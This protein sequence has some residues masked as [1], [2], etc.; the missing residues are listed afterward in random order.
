MTQPTL[1]GRIREQ[2]ALR[3]CLDAALESQGRLILVCGEAGIGK[4]TLVADLVREAQQRGARVATGHCYDLTETPPY[5]P[6]TEILERL[7]AGAAAA[8]GHTP[9]AAVPSTHAPGPLLSTPVTGAP[10][11]AAFG[12]AAG[13][14]GG[15]ANQAGLFASVR[16]RLAAAAAQQPLLV[17][18][19]DMHWSD[20]GSLELLRWIARNALDMRL[21]LVGTY[22]PADIT[23]RHPLFALLPLLVREVDPVRLDL[24]RLEPDTVRALVMDRYPLALEQADLSRLADYL[25]KHAAGNPLYIG[26]LLRMLEE[27]RLLEPGQP[28]WILHELNTAPVPPLLR[29]V[30]ERR[31]LRLGEAA[32]A[33][34]EVAAVI[35]EH[36]S[37][38]LLETVAD[39]ANAVLLDIVDAAVD[40]RLLEA[41]PDGA[42]VRFAHALVREAL[43]EALVPPRRRVWHLRVAEALLADPALDPDPDNVAYHLQRGG[44]P[45]AGEWLVRAGERAQQR[46]ALLTAADR[47]EAALRLLEA[48]GAPGAERAGMLYRVARMR[49]YANPRQALVHLDDALVL[50]ESV[51]DRVLAAYVASFRGALRCATGELR[52][53]LDELEAGV[54][55]I[56]ALPAAKRARLRALQERFGDPP[57][58]Y[59]YRGALVNWLAVA[60]RCAEAL[61]LGERLVARPRAAQRRG[62][63]GYA[64]TLRGVASAC[65]A[66]GRPS[67]ARQAYASAIGS[68]RAVEHHYQVGNALVLE[69]FEVVLT[70]QTD[71]VSE[72]RRL[73]REACEAWTRAGEV[74]EDLTP[75]FAQ[76]PLLVLEGDWAEA[77]ELALGATAEGSR[78]SWRPLA[79]SLLAR[80]ARE[81]G[82]PDLAWRLI[83]EQLPAGAATP[84]GDAILLDT[85]ILLRLAA[86]LTIQ[87]EPAA[88][89]PWLEAHDR[90]IDW[91][92]AVLGRAEGHLA[93][94]AYHLATGDLKSAGRRATA[95][96]ES[97]SAPRQPLALLAA[98]LLLGELGTASHHF[99]VAATHFGQAFGIAEAC[100]APSERSTV[101]LAQAE[102]LAAQGHRREARRLVEEI[103]AVATR[104]GAA[105]LL[106]RTEALTT[107]LAMAP[108]A[109][110]SERELEVLR[111]VAEA[112]TDAQVADRLSLSPRTVGQHLRSIY[113]KLGVNSRAAAT[114]FAVE[115][116]LV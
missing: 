106:A 84:P 25:E 72:R 96:L 33:C 14:L 61:E 76:L 55:A 29:Q 22:R 77:R 109:G 11:A 88:A 101:L 37:L 38:R 62:T 98:H 111:L 66:L 51:D 19:E 2:A 95:A 46:Y 36:V 87:T 70:Y 16:D 53:G 86:L 68:Y 81:Q 63:S 93:W 73:A 54:A 113:N 41:A 85:L 102:L 12:T 43:Y 10:G 20:V 59:H 31:L 7:S 1:T 80:I 4:T 5:G 60:G 100:S 99:D 89:R 49:R 110:L 83:H 3:A 57:D 58:E 50:A 28:R 56:V 74:L 78:T 23:Q 17:V 26:E 69:L 115:N 27:E 105:P 75:R 21:L 15:V 90:W 47:F 116:G 65:A 42:T 103:R 114:R 18:L 30:I 108:S 112:L 45:R 40:A 24:R 71:D 52:R 6:W 32:Y 79:A 107:H 64:N 97:A 44:D 104:L 8:A 39:V 94:A 91:S 92:Q 48:H 13:G 35:G 34:L 9:A 82:E 67:E